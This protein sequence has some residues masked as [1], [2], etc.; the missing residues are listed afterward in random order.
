[1]KYLRRLFRKPVFDVKFRVRM[2]Q[3]VGHISMGSMAL[4]LSSSWYWI[5][6]ST[7]VQNG[8]VRVKVYAE[9]P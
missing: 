9:E 3:E 7:G 1:M 8:D 2:G 6:S 5:V 4:T